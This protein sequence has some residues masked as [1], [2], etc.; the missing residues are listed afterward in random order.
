MYRYRHNVTGTIITV[1][2]ELRGDSW[3]LV[4]GDEKKAAPKPV[5]KTTR[6]KVQKDG[7]TV[8]NDQ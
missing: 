2:T 3:S 8:H 6:K 4:E 5:R 7:D 1:P